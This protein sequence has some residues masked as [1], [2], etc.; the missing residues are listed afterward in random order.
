MGRHDFGSIRFRLRRFPLRHRIFSGTGCGFGFPL[1]KGYGVTRLYERFAPQFFNGA[2]PL[3]FDDARGHCLR[4]SF[5]LLREKTIERKHT[6][7]DKL[8]LRNLHRQQ[9]RMFTVKDFPLKKNRRG[10]PLRFNNF[11]SC[12]GFNI[13]TATTL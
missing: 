12:G 9:D 3:L 4:R 1:R 10:F 11:Y 8:R 6:L 13:P 7:R 5:L 2:N